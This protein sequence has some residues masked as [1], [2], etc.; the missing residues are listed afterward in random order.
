[1]IDGKSLGDTMPSTLRQSHFN[2][3]VI[4]SGAARRVA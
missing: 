1:M 2:F 4:P 3:S